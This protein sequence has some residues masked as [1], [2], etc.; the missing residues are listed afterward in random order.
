MTPSF[1]EILRGL[2]DNRDLS[3]RAISRVREI[4]PTLQ[5]SDQIGD[6]VLI[7]ILRLG[8]GKAFDE[9]SIYFPHA[10]TATIRTATSTLSPNCHP[11]V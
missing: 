1:A 8:Q 5:I 2:M 3:P 10:Y 9:L 11:E 7:A 6:L 4:A